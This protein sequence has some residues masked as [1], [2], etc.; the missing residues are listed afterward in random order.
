MD[1]FALHK[2]RT[3]P[4]AYCKRSK[5]VEGECGKMCKDNKAKKK[6]GRG[7]RHVSSVVQKRV[8]PTLITN[9]S[10]PPRWGT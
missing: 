5:E 8:R 1:H 6:G 9:P 4:I 3:D 10:Y 2:Q 7:E